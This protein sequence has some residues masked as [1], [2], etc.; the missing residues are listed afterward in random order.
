MAYRAGASIRDLEFVQFHPT[1]L[2]VGGSPTPLITEALRGEGALL[3]NAAGERFMAAVDPKAELA[4]RDVV[5]RGM[6]AEMRARGL[7]ARLPGRD[8]ARRR[9]AA[10]SVSRV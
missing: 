2:A 3:R 9:H 10:R 4:A 8:R 7:V 1:G 5:V 6:V